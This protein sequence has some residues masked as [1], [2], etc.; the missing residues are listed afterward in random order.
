M[1]FLVSHNIEYR[2]WM[3][4]R[5][6]M[7][8]MQKR[9]WLNHK[10]IG[11]SNSISSIFSQVITKNSKQAKT[12]YTYYKFQKLFKAHRWDNKLTASAQL[13]NSIFPINYKLKPKG[14]NL[15]ISLTIGLNSF[16]TL[17]P[18]PAPPYRHC[19]VFVFS[20]LYFLGFYFMSLLGVPYN[21]YPTCVLVGFFKT[22]YTPLTIFIGSIILGIRAKNQ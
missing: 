4:N 19:V 22:L 16:H 18:T 8:K 2:K 14:P 7:D 5:N 12:L 21:C 9:Y 20:L 6:G 1:F 10:N 3:K 15:I 17:L 13:T 11:L